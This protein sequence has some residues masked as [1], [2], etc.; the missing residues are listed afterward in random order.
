MRGTRWHLNYPGNL[1]H[2]HQ[3]P[4]KHGLHAVRWQQHQ[5]SA[6]YDPSCWA[7]PEPDPGVTAMLR[8]LQHRQLALLSAHSQHLQ[9]KE[10]SLLSGHAERCISLRIFPKSLLIAC[11]GSKFGKNPLSLCFH[12]KSKSP[13]CFQMQP[14]LHGNTYNWGG[15]ISHSIPCF[16]E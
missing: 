9:E 5:P 8:S 4:G 16:P 2:Q 3:L 12:T 1:K 10:I 14:I 11:N 15:C 13:S 7:Q 6:S